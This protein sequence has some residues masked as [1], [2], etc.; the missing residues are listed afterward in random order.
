MGWR[1]VLGVSFSAIL[2]LSGWAAAQPV[3]DP[4]ARALAEERAEPPADAPGIR[5]FGR[6]QAHALAD[7]RQQFA[8]DLGV[9]TARIGVEATFRNL[10]AV[11]EADL[12]SS[13]PLRDAYV[14]LRDDADRYRFY[15]GRFKAPFLARQLQSSW[16]LPMVSRGLVDSYLVD[17][18][19][20]GGR[21]YGLMGEARFKELSGLKASFGLFRGS[22]DDLQGRHRAEDAAGR[23][24]L[25]ILRGVTVGMSGY[26]AEALAGRDQRHAYAA[27]VR[28]RVGRFEVSVEGLRGRVARG[29]IDAG[30]VLG[31]FDLLLDVDREWILQPAVGAEVMRL[32]AEEVGTGHALTA[33][34]NLLHRDRF[35]LQLQAERALRPNDRSV[36]HQLALQVG[37]RF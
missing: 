25:R 20:L 18:H 12:S 36:A 26:L 34:V 28:A 16:Q 4:E 11:V 27:D 33:G 3:A 2:L 7:E 35:K 19:D 9:A 31:T 14:R 37:A 13:S 1:G 17:T 8:R 23:V 22:Y 6:V 21:R 15:A 32:H 24:S 5:V 29:G 10:E 30:L